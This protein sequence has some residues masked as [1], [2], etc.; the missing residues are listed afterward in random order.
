[1]KETWEKERGLENE[2]GDEEQAKNKLEKIG[3]KSEGR[4]REMRASVE[5]PSREARKR[6]LEKEGRKEQTWRRRR[7]GEGADL[8]EG[9]DLEK[10][11]TWRRH[12]QRILI[13]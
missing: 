13:S 12:S 2:A 5:R 6:D 4:P 10:E 9:G 7:L 1:M 8:G 11:E 3:R